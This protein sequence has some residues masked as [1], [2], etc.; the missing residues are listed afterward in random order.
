MHPKPI[1]LTPE[2][3]HRI[4]VSV[5]HLLLSVP[6]SLS[7]CTDCGDY[8]NRIIPWVR[9]CVTRCW[10]SGRT[11]GICLG[12]HGGIFVRTFLIFVGHVHSKAS[13]KVAVFPR[14][15][16]IISAHL[17][18]FSTLRLVPIDSYTCRVSHVSCPYAAARWVQPSFGAAVS[19]LQ[20]HLNRHT[21]F[22]GR[23]GWLGA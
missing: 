18:H 23:I 1:A 5:S 15:N 21:H 17:W 11:V 3:F 9:V 2:R 20:V 19:G 6:M 10:T 7:R 14:R 13:S 22:S 4:A 12:R 16:D 8:R